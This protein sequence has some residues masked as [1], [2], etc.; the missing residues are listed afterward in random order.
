MQQV[1]VVIPL[2]SAQL[3]ERE[4]KSLSQAYRV[5]RAHPLII[6]KPESLDISDILHTFPG[7]SSC[8][9][10]DAFFKGIEGY[11][12]L[13]LSAPFYERFLE[14]EYI[15]IYQLDAYVFRDELSEWCAREYDYI[16]APWLEKPVYRL[17][18]VSCYMR[19]LHQRKIRRGKLSKQSLYNKIG[20][21]GFSLRRTASHY[22]VTQNREETIACFL[23]QK[24]SHFFNEDVF[25]ATQVPEFRY[26][27]VREALRFSFD[28]Y[29]AYCYRL[30]EKRL[31]FGCHAWYKRK[32]KHFW[33]PIIRF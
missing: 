17:P 29:P 26:P 6:V 30:N 27:D 9:F 14:S 10:A 21:G 24:H 15:L 4:L 23:A 16:G 28:K 31:P 12:R 25:W 22:R 2:Y 33:R 7:I 1:S 19:W 11:N 18:P 8:S 3:S 13:M 32:M 5:L 20:N